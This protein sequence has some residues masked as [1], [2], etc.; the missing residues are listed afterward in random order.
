[1]L[2]TLPTPYVEQLLPIAHRSQSV[3][4]RRT[5][6]S[7]SAKHAL[8]RVKKK[9]FLLTG[10]ENM[11]CTLPTGYVKQLLS[12]VH[13]SQSAG[14]YIFFKFGFQCSLIGFCFIKV[15]QSL[16]K[17]QYFKAKSSFLQY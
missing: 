12:I 16:I 8:V 6:A 14:K 4:F 11:L 17:V 5:F 13:C 10:S 2:C 3:R 1:M 9:N 15:N 7:S